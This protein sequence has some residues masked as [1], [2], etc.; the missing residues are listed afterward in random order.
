MKIRNFTAGALIYSGHL[1]HYRNIH[2]AFLVI[3]L[4]MNTEGEKL[5]LLLQTK[6]I[7]FVLVQCNILPSFHFIKLLCFNINGLDGEIMS[8]SLL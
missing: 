6:F 4:N 1:F 2:M 3:F 5:Q 8:E 7:L